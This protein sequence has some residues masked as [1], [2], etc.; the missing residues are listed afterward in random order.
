MLV[1]ASLR[2]RKQKCSGSVIERGE[3]EPSMVPRT[4]FKK[5]IIWQTV[6]GNICQDYTH[7]NCVAIPGWSSRTCLVSKL[8]SGFSFLFCRLPSRSSQLSRMQGDS[9][10]ACSRV[11]SD[12]KKYPFFIA[13]LLEYG[14][15]S[16]KT[17]GTARCGLWTCTWQSSSES[18]HGFCW[19]P[20]SRSFPWSSWVIDACKITM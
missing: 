8:T 13:L 4:R 10:W 5:R 12:R 3:S 17:G 15:N 9:S 14:T 16:G 7:P 18:L 2:A 20:T 1:R 19:R 6:T 11:T